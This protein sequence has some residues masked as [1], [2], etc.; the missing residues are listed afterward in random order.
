MFHET[1]EVTLEKIKEEKRTDGC[2]FIL[3]FLNDSNNIYHWI[4]SVCLVTL[5]KVRKQ[6]EKK[7]EILRGYY[8]I[9]VKV[10]P[11]YS[12][13]VRWLSSAIVLLPFRHLLGATLE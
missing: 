5:S 13:T 7:K 8:I 9:I 6:V 3:F 4:V 12:D 2:I 1:V 11:R 10:R